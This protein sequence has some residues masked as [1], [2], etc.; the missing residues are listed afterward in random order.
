MKSINFTLQDV[1]VDK[2]KKKKKQI[3]FGRFNE[4]FVQVNHH[5]NVSLK[6]IITQTFFRSNYRSTV[7]VIY[8]VVQFFS[9]ARIRNKK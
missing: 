2:K 7:T 4:E 5:Q 3:L 9:N 1:Y 8:P 6:R